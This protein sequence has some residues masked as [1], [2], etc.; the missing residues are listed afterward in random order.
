MKF[1]SHITAAKVELAFETFYFL[2]TVAC[3]IIAVVSGIQENYRKGA[4]YAVFGV[5]LVAVRRKS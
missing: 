5:G 2:C 4:F 1:L 3:L